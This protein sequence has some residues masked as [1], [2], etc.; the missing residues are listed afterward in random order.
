MHRPTTLLAVCSLLLIFNVKASAQEVSLGGARQMITTASAVR[1]RA[2][3]ET[4][5]AEVARLRL[6]TVVSADART[7]VE[8]EV[9]S[10]KEYW[11]RVA[12]PGGQQ[13]W[14][15]GALLADFD[16]RRGSETVLR[17]AE[18]RLK[19]EE[20]SRDDSLDLFNFVEG[21]VADAR[22]PAR[23]E[24]E[25]VRLHA[26][27][28]AVRAMGTDDKGRMSDAEFQKAH[29]REIYY[30]ELAG[31]WGVKPEAFWKL[32]TKYR[33]TTLGDRIAWEA[34]QALYPGECESDEVC[35]FLRLQD[36]QGRYLGLYPTGAHAEEALRNIKEA[37]ASQALDET[38]KRKG[39]DVYARQEQDALKKALAELRA[40]VSKTNA[41]EKS[42]I[43]RRLEQLSPGGTK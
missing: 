30:H 19:V 23:D 16:P 4:G 42:D 8:T 26:L 7:G 17:I 13:G 43:L 20:M 22:G 33:G 25:R 3:P 2:S 12:L 37:L 31:G 35:Q 24:L 38:A 21:A 41:P 1:V 10:K 40:A 11:Y 15:F 27:D 18:E 39:G 36:T 29:E 14:V 28:R 34:S 5:A 32:E 9:G 6:G